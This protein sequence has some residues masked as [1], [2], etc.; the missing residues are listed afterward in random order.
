M[1]WGRKLASIATQL[2]PGQ[3]YSEDSAT[4]ETVLQP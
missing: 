1:L 3:R 4:A 2:Q